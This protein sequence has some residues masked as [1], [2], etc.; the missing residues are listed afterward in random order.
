MSARKETIKVLVADDHPVVRK[1]LQSCLSRA[2]RLRLVGEAADGDEALRKARELQPDVVLM[3]IS[4]P[5]MNG[6]MVTEMLRKELPQVKVLVVSVQR[7]KDAIFRVI[8]AGA[9]GYVSKEAPSEEVIRA[10]ESVHGG[11]PYFSEEIA[12]AALY[13]FINS[14]GR[15][16][17]FAQLTP[18]EREVLVLI[19]EG[20]S[21]KEI[22][23][24]LNIGVRTIETHRERIMRRLNIHSVAGLT[25]Y[26][27]A[28]GLVTLDIG[29]KP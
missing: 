16:E 5:G 2:G 17:P 18:R 24:Q 3:D 8:Q 19:A 21:N 20:K 22:A 27:I 23:D 29:P 15:K 6:L 14:G 4:M 7:N 1:G 10:I 11:E 28:N 12:R 9:H 25:K 13:E 26:A